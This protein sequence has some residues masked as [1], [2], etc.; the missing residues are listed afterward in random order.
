MASSES[1]R[2]LTEGIQQ[3]KPWRTNMII[4]FSLFI[5]SLRLA[6]AIVQDSDMAAPSQECLRRV[7]KLITDR[8]EAVHQ[9]YQPRRCLFFILA[10]QSITIARRFYIPIFTTVASLQTMRHADPEG[11]SYGNMFTNPTDLLLNALAIMFMLELDEQIC[12]LFVSSARE[13][14]IK[15]RLNGLLVDGPKIEKCSD[16]LP[17]DSP[18]PRDSEDL[19]DSHPSSSAKGDTT[20]TDSFE[21][22]NSEGTNLLNR[23][24]ATV[25]IILL[26][27]GYY[28][29]DGDG[30]N[31]VFTKWA[32][33]PMTP[34]VIRNSTGAE[35]GFVCEDSYPEQ[36][37]ELAKSAGCYEYGY[38]H[39][40]DIWSDCPKSCDLCDELAEKHAKGQTNLFCE[41]YWGNAMFIGATQWWLALSVWGVSLS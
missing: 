12:V 22:P 37:Q 35:S 25:C 17:V 19:S 5:V 27:A 21:R 8:S 26:F 9:L 18:K 10:M 30:L 40:Y 34:V 32:G 13:T 39:T 14:R 20:T 6:S 36:C 41:V 3:V 11:E 1:R 31:V 7:A 15:N 28:S 38:Y 29:G 33:F 2:I 24:T 16:D 23:L 4:F